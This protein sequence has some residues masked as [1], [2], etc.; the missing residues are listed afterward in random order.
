MNIFKLLLIISSVN[1]KLWSV[2]NGE[3]IYNNTIPYI[4]RG[5]NWNGIESDCLVSHGLWANP[6]MYYINLLKY[7]GFNSIRTPIS[8]EVMRNL[9]MIVNSYCVKQEPRLIGKTVEEY[10]YIY[11]DTLKNLGIT[12]LVDLHTIDGRIT[13]YP[14]D[15]YI[16][17]IDTINTWVDF[18]NKFGDR[19][20]AIELKN[21][22]H[23][24]C[25]F[26]DFI[27]WCKDVIV[28]IEQKT[29][30]TGLYFISGTQKSVKDNS[31]NNAWGGTFSDINITNFPIEYIDR[32]VLSPHVYG[33]SVRSDSVNGDNDDTWYNAFGFI[34]K[35]NW[36]LNKLPIIYTEIG[37]FL[38]GSDMTYYMRFLDWVFRNNLNKG[39]YWWTLPT[40]SIDT[41]G[42]FY[43]ENM[44]ELNWLK[45]NF[46]KSFIPNP[47]YV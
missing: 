33:T 18:L 19:I 47:T 23:G 25:T 24:P 13:E 8:Y 4:V 10:L 15:N 7:H 17:Y 29:N 9:N 11:F 16:S 2:N 5:I 42:L 34:S 39:M 31:M 1:A 6:F 21:E 43:D 32:I 22:P 44:N 28:N 20:F 46:I 30:Y 3:I 27:I 36:I 41:G 40:T 12:V 38:I 45:L 37:G 35:K 26:N 14:Y